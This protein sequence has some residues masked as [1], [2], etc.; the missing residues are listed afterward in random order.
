MRKHLPQYLAIS[1]F[2]LLFGVFGLFPMVFLGYLAFH[3]WDG[4]GEMRFVGLD[5]F[6]F[7]VT[8]DFDGNHR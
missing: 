4:I 3:T 1:P 5:Q 8:A 6:K 7:L 2:F